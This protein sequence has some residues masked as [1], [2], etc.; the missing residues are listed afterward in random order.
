[1]IREAVS[2]GDM[3]KVAALLGTPY[4]INGT[5]VYGRKLGRKLGMPTVNLQPANEK[6]LP[7]NGVYCSYTWVDGIRYPAI[8]NVGFKP[9]VSDEPIVGVETYIYDFD[10]NVY[11]SEITVELLHFKRAEMKFDSIEALKGQMQKDIDEG[12][13]FHHSFDK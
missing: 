5:V 12:M 2:R 9:T 3:E 6:L 11:G 1:L 4:S 8:S 7:P 13:I 10:K